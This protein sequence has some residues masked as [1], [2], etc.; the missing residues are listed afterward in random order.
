MAEDIL[1]QLKS[2]EDEMEALINEARKKAASIREEALKKAKEIKSAKIK[3]TEAELAGFAGKK[4]EAAELEA[5]SIEKDAVKRAEELKKKG[6]ARKD[7][8][9]KAV[10]RFINEGLGER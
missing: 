4:R 3:E 2:K 10:V 7:E 9:V 5:A 6:V 8:A 1:E